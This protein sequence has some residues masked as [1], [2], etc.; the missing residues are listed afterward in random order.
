MIYVMAHNK[1]NFENYKMDPEWDEN[2]FSFF[3]TEGRT[4][5]TKVSDTLIKKIH[6][7]NFQCIL[8]WELPQYNGILQKKRFFAPSILYHYHTN[9]EA[10]SSELKYMGFLE[11]DL[12]LE[13][14]TRITK[15]LENSSTWMGD[16]SF[17]RLIKEITTEH[18]K[19]PFIILPSIR[20]SLALLDSQQNIRMHNHHWLKFFLW[21]YNKRYNTDYEYHQFIRDYGECLIP[22]Q[23]SF[24]SDVHTA[25]QVFAYA[26][27]FI[28]EYGYKHQNIDKIYQPFPATIMER[29][30]GMFIFL[31]TKNYANK[32]IIPLKHLHA[33]SG[34]YN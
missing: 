24:I 13:L 32:H 29:F 2:L 12:A 21:D 10:I 23:Q 19:D 9:F 7:E 4:K 33:S 3:L 16:F 22:T 34:N 1:I 14:D 15:K 8:E 5:N 11:Y 6:A 18:A 31:Y 20:H 17:C 30:I 25:K 26:Y 28:E 27:N